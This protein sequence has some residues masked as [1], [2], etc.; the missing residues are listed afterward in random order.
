MA[1]LREATDFELLLVLHS[2]CLKN[3]LTDNEIKNIALDFGLIIT[4]VDNDEISATLIDGV[5][6]LT[7]KHK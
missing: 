4:K 5:T 1:N 6:I 3:L 2:I 7:I